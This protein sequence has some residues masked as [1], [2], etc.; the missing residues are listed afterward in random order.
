[1]LARQAFGATDRTGVT[2]ALLDWIGEQPPAEQDI[3]GRPVLAW[4][5]SRV[6]AIAKNGCAILG[7]RPLE[8]DNIHAPVLMHAVGEK[9]AVWGWRTI[10]NRAEAH[11]LG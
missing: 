2:I 4:A 1:M 8:A 11:F 9:S 3:A 6:D 7:N 10:V 5:L